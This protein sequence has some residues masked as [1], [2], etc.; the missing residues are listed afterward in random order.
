MGIKGL[1]HDNINTSNKKDTMSF[2]TH[3]FD[4][5]EGFWSAFDF[6]VTWLGRGE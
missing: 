1:D 5:R 3:L 6:P 2:Y 4:F